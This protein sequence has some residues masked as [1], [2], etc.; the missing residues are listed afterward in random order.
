MGQEVPGLT[1][2]DALQPN[3]GWLDAAGRL[4]IQAL[5]LFLPVQPENNYP[6]LTQ[7]MTQVTFQLS[8]STQLFF[9]KR[10]LIARSEHFSRML[11][12]SSWKEGHT[13]IVDLSCNPDATPQA[14]SAVLNFLAHEKFHADGDASLGCLVRRLADQF[15]LSSLVQRVDEELKPPFLV[16]NTCCSSLQQTWLWLRS[17]CH[18]KEAFLLTIGEFVPNCLINSILAKSA[19]MEM[20]T[21]P[22]VWPISR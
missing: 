20:E 4:R 1:V 2:A 17:F 15:Q 5:V 14:V 13:N 22:A 18:Q 3:A 8:G 16:E 6:D 11:S 7:P 21:V 9:D 19:S 10:V 12:S